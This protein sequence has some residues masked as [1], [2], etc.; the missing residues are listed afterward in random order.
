VHTK[1]TATHEI[2]HFPSAFCSEC[3]R[4]RRS[5]SRVLGLREGL[6]EAGTW[7]GSY[8][9]NNSKTDHEVQLSASRSSE[10]QL[11]GFALDERRGQPSLARNASRFTGEDA[12]GGY[13]YLA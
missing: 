10:L 12:T 11:S 4:G 13:P 1:G 5:L 3:R 9:L 7:Q 2:T 8:K 6:H